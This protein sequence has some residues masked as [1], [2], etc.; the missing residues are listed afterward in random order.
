MHACTCALIAHLQCLPEASAVWQAV[1]A[2]GER[3]A[4]PLPLCSVALHTQPVRIVLIGQ[5]SESCAFAPDGEALAV[6]LVSGGIKVLTFYPEVR[7][8]RRTMRVCV[9][10]A[11]RGSGP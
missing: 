3:C 8:V 9:L 11:Q 5:P 1:G 10:C 4:L 7:Q 6:G 2:E